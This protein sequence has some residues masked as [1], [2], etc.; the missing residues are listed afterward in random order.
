MI[1]LPHIW[2]QDH[3]NAVNDGDPATSC[4]DGASPSQTD[5][6]PLIGCYFSASKQQVLNLRSN[7]DGALKLNLWF[8]LFALN[9]TIAM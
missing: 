6:R 4:E 8:A 2:H 5:I 7:S 9:F 3:D 1:V